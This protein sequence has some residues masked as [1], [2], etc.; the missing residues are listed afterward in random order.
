MDKR[1]QSRARLSRVQFGHGT[2]NPLIVTKLG[3]APGLALQALVGYGLGEDDIARYLGMT[4]SS[5]RRLQRV[6]D[7]P[8]AKPHR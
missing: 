3:A 8:S 6:L 7:P 1:Q 5:V 4:P 2:R